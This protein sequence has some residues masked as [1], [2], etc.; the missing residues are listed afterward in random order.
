MDEISLYRLR[1]IYSTDHTLTEKVAPLPLEQSRGGTY[2]QEISVVTTRFLTADR[3]H[4]TSAHC[5][6]RFAGLFHQPLCLRLILALCM[7]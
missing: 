6:D 5:D 7:Q 2:C 4:I 1:Q 3:L